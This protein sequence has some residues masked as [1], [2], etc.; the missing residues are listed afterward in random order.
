MDAQVAG[1]NKRYCPDSF[2][3]LLQFGNWIIDVI[4]DREPESNRAMS[5][6]FGSKG[7]TARDQDACI[8]DYF[9]YSKYQERQLQEAFALNG[10]RRFRLQRNQIK[11]NIWNV[12]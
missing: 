11:N 2:F 9:A 4:D 3:K 12:K 5:V 8:I 1:K 7:A 6:E 10:G